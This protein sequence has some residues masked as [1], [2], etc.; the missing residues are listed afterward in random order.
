MNSIAERKGN[1]NSN[2]DEIIELKDGEKYIL[3]Y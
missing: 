2:I 3:D 1:N